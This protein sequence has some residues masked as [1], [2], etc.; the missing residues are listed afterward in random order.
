MAPVYQNF[1]R[2][3]RVLGGGP[4]VYWKTHHKRTV[5]FKKL[6]GTDHFYSCISFSVNV[7]Y[8]KDCSNALY[9]KRSIMSAVFDLTNK[10]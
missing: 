4:V 10:Y 6:I 1:C 7:I 3:T 9:K 2:T 8:G 5:F